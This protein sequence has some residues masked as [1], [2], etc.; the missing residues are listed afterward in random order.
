MRYRRWKG[1]IAALSI[2]CLLTAPAAAALVEVDGVA[3]TPEQG[4]VSDGV[5]Y[6]TLRTLAQLEGYGLCWDG[7]QAVLTGEGL[8]LTAIPGQP[9]LEVNGR[10]LYVREG[11]GSREG[12]SY[13]P[14]SVVAD[15]MGGSLSWDAST[16]TARL[17][18]KNALP[19][20]ADYDP[21]ELYWLSRIISAESRGE[22]LLGQIAVG[23]VVLNRVAHENYP[24]TVKGVVFD[25]NYGVQ[26]EPVANGTVYL[27][28]VPT[29]VLA[30]KLCLEGASVVADSLYFF[31]PALSAGTWIV[32]N[33]KYH[34]TIG[35]HKFYE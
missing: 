17:S 20:V 6:I 35:C 7:T 24:D 8:E 3:L 30:A 34:T 29:S 1:A 10:A 12:R 5:S 27:D 9:Y 22:V 4:W 28:P 18:L 25:R 26:F 32:E 19:P 14:M 23:N 13:L 11:V 21:E 2:T 31:A 15:A 16:A 33:G